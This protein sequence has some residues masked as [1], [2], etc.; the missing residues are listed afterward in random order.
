[1]SKYTSLILY[2]SGLEELDDRLKE[3]N[4]FHNN[5]FSLKLFDVNENFYPDTFPRFTYVGAYNYFDTKVFVEHIRDKV[6]WDYPEYVQ[7]FIQEEGYANCT[8]YINAC[9]DLLYSAEKLY[10]IE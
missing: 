5:S 8:I 9:K 7:L 4:S 10:N 6:N 2:V 1:M 3:V